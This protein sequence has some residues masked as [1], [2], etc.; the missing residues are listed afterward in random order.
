MGEGEDFFQTPLLHFTFF[1][2]TPFPHYTTIR[3]TPPSLRIFHGFRL[4]F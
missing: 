2:W 1:D 4:Y 3:W